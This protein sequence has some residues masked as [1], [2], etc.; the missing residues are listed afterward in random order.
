MTPAAA[1]APAPT[2]PMRRRRL[3]QLGHLHTALAGLL[4]AAGGAAGIGARY[5]LAARSSDPAHLLAA[6]N[7]GDALFVLSLLA[8][9]PGFLIGRALVRR[10]PR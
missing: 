6:V 3:Q 7:I 5:V 10:R 9:L 1:T 8:A 4:V 2:A